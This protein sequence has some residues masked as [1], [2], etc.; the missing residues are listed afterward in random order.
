M[1]NAVVTCNF[2]WHPAHLPRGHVLDGEL[3]EVGLPPPLVPRV[4]L[5]GLRDHGRCRGRR[6]RA[7]EQRAASRVEARLQS[8][9]PGTKHVSDDGIV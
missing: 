5:L 9:H 3:G 2:S 7:E 8:T 6:R 1:N 4:L